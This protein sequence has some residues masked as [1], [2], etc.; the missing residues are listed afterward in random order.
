MK[1]IRKRSRLTSIYAEVTPDEHRALRIESAS[2]GISITQMIRN[3]LINPIVVK[4][5][6]EAGNGYI[7]HQRV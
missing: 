1:T 3:K 6:K 2:T 4:Q 7:E 5:K